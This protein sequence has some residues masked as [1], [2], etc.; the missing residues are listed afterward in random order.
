MGWAAWPLFP[1][2]GCLLLSVFFRT[3]SGCPLPAHRTLLLCFAAL[4]SAFAIFCSEGQ[5]KQN[6]LCRIENRSF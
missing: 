5:V 4:F 1:G 2:I 3:K 6:G